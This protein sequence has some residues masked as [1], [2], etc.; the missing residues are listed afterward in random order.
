MPESRL[1]ILA[2]T[3]RYR[4]ELLSR[5]GL[6]FRSEDP[7]VE[8]SSSAGESPADTAI[9][10]S[11]AKARAVAARFPDAMVIGSDQVAS[12][13]ELRMGKPGTHERA[14]AQLAAMSGRAVR[15]DTAVALLDARSGEMQARLVPTIVT[16]RP[17][18]A[19]EIESY[20]RRE[21][22]YDCAG[23]AKIERM[24]I[25]LV[26]RVQSEDP[27]ALIGLPLIALTQMLERGGIRVVGA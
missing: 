15:F 9:R 7:A 21:R 13:G 5:L 6:P 22:P 3:S 18:S 11:Q 14:V 10:L 24:G 16:F 25:A 8:E 27:T 4:Q 26:E 2:S 12:C 17:L 23:S 1:L 20:L 19:D